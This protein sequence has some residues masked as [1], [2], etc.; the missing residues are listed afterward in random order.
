MPV[1]KVLIAG[2]TGY[3][4]KFLLKE[5]RQRGYWVRA[6]A[7]STE[8][9][10]DVRDCVDDV[11]VGEA[12]KPDTLQGLCE[13]IDVVI[14]ALGVASSRTN[15]TISLEEVDYGGNS[16]IL[17]R[18][19][20]AGV[21]KFIY[22]AFVKTA[23][24]EHLEITRIKEHFVSELRDSRLNYCV[25]RPTAFF[26]DMGEFVKQALNGTVYLVGNGQTRVNPIHGS[27]LA[28]VCLDAVDSSET[29]VSVG[30]PEIYSYEEA[31]KL[32][33]KILGKEPR[34]KKI[35]LWPFTILLKLIRPFIRRR[36]FTLIQFLLAA[37][38]KDSVVQKYGSY[39]LEKFFR[40]KVEQGQ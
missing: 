16:N 13:G 32:A 38:T 28:Q 6:L 3:L 40:E 29:E 9:L 26:S 27:D 10:D 30:G 14:S 37:F 24:F 8:K 23:D 34:I 5:C 31:A 15:E 4:G 36:K 11:F 22:V 33:F 35:P 2:A 17:K 21:Q 39:T 20:E 19:E 7:R 12:T 1:K 18:A 25:M